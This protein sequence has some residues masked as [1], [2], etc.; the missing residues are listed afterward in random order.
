MLCSYSK[1]ESVDLEAIQGLEK[2]LGKTLLA[3]SCQDIKP[4]E[5]TDEDLAKISELEKKLGIVLVAVEH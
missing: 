3:F 4:A 2:A 1:T 5:L